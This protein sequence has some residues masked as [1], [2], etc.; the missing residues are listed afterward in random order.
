[1]FEFPLVRSIFI[2][3]FNVCNFLKTN[4]KWIAEIG[5]YTILHVSFSTVLQFSVK[6]KFEKILMQIFF[7]FELFDPIFSKFY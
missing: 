6:F 5:V 7:S 2:S 1:M 4:R 3:K